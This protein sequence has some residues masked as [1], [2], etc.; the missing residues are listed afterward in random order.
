[1]LL[2]NFYQNETDALASIF[3]CKYRALKLVTLEKRV[4]KEIDFKLSRV[5]LENP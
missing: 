2:E 1:M 3:I 5:T 4:K